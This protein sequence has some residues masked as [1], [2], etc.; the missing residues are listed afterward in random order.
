MTA[1]CPFCGLPPER[2][3]AQTDL[4][5][6]AVP[7]APHVAPDDGGHLIV[8]PRRHVASRR[9]IDLPEAVEMWRLSTIAAAALERVLGVSWFNYQENG[10]WTVDDPRQRHLHLHVYGRARDSRLQP[11][12][13]SLRFPRRDA[14]ERWD[15][16]PFTEA[17]VAALRRAVQADL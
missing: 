17:H 16:T 14:L 1:T 5:S 10:N 6:I 7:A 12:G 4:A 13:E 9:E 11:F 3:L 15:R 8:V 2:L